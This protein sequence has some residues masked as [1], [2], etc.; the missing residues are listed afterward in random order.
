MDELLPFLF[1]RHGET[2]WNRAG[3]F[4]GRT[5][6]LLN[7]TGRKQARELAPKLAHLPVSKIFVSPLTR[8]RAT[9]ALAF[10]S[11]VGL[12]E[13]ENLLIECDFGGLDGKPIMAAMREHGITHKEDLKNILPRDAE[14]W[15]QVMGRVTELLAKMA[16]YQKLGGTIV[17]VGHDAVLQGISETLT[18]RWFNSAHG[19]PYQFRR[20]P[21]G[22]EVVEH[23]DNRA[24]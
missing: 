18:G 12:I 11:M 15:A 22:W 6:I 7:N 20:V 16:I 21:S 8:A 13:V 14:T 1:I 2:D 9:A 5:D 17:L 3:L 23:Y 19:C 24:S 10:P 4:Q